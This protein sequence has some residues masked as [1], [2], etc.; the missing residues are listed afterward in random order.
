MPLWNYG[1]QVAEL[2]HPLV[3]EQREVVAVV[4]LMHLQ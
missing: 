3:R 2:A 4:V 1:V